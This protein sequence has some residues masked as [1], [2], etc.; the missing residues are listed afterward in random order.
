MTRLA[1]TV[2]PAPYETLTSFVSRLAARNGCVSASEFCSDLGLDW[3]SIVR[4]DDTVFREIA[5]LSG[6]AET[7][8]WQSAVRT[9]VAGKMK[10]GNEIGTHTLI[11]KSSPRVCPTCLLEDRH[12]EG[13]CGGAGRVIWTV[14]AIHRCHLHRQRLM[15]LATDAPPVTAHD[16]H[17][18][19]RENWN[20]IE[21][22]SQCITDAGGETSLENYLRHRISGSRS[23]IWP[24]HLPLYVA[25]RTSE[26]L[27]CRMLFGS[28]QLF[29][30]LT[31]EQ[32]REAGAA[33]FGVLSGGPDS[34]R[35]ALRSFERDT[36]E[37][38][39]YHHRDYGRFFTW[40]SDPAPL[41]TSTL[42][43]ISCA[44]TF[45]PNIRVKK[46]RS[47]WANRCHRENSI[48]SKRHGAR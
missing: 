43:R 16:L 3:K 48:R 8:L 47:S 36:C 40:L 33:G 1:L 32:M 2:D 26:M 18:I 19:I 24:D 39:A 38:R 41:R 4:G 34:I 46:E 6:A 29:R 11:K 14:I 28:T 10:I 22:A 7:M 13:R 31:P 35:E 25:A 37:V 17:P 5:A 23:G 21:A 42:S 12:R 45:S 20:A 44:I 27:G 30:K 9:T 15:T